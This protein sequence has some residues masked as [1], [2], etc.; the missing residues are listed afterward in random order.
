MKR[1][2]LKSILCS[3]LIAAMLAAPASA[4]AASKVCYI[5]KVAVSNAPGTYMRSGKTADSNA[6]IGSLR[7]GTKVLYYGTKSSMNE[8]MLKVLTP[9]GKRGYVYKGNLNTYGAATAR[10]IYLTT[11]SSTGVYKKAGSKYRK[12]GSVGKGIPVV[13][14]KSKGKW[15][16]V[17]NMNGTSAYIKTSALKRLG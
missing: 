3:L 16:R 8:Q 1:N 5:F 2:I 13:V 17:R 14:Y 11:Q 10:Q 15:S 4:L 6:I 12:V 9:D 7:N